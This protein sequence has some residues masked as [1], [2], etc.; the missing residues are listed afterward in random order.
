MV[1]RAEQELRANIDRALLIGDHVNWSIPIEA[2]LPFSIVWLRLNKLA[3]QREP[4]DSPNKAA[5]RFGI[6][7]ACI[8]RIGKYPET[9]SAKNIFPVAIVEP[10]R[11]LRVA[12]PNAVVLQPAEYVI[13]VG[14]VHTDVIELRDGKIVALPP[15]IAAVVGIP[16]ASVIAGDDMV[17]II[18]IHPHVVEIPVRAV[19]DS[20]EAPAAILAHNHREVRLVNFVLV[21]RIADQDGKITR[22]PDHPFT[23]F[24]L[25]P[26]LP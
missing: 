21:L 5:L 3:F 24:P 4:I 19:P 12:H 7:I 6:N 26:R 17:G 16:N 20:A 14:V 18:G 10:A 22:S 15:G 2:Q 8:G 11:I 23:P 9:I 1:A 13:G 25:S